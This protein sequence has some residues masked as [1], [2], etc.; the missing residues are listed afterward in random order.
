MELHEIGSCFF[1]CLFFPLNSIIY[2]FTSLNLFLC[3]VAAIFRNQI[4]FFISKLL[5]P[6]SFQSPY[7]GRHPLTHTGCA[8]NVS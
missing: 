3:T 8:A 7:L 1:V 4:L 6:D 5:I 2:G